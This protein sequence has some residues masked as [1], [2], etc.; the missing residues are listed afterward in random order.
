MA[1]SRAARGPRDPRTQHQRLSLRAAISIL[2]Q[3]RKVGIRGLQVARLN[4]VQRGHQ[5]FGISLQRAFATVTEEKYGG[6]HQQREHDGAH[7]V[8]PVFLPDAEILIGAYRV[9][10]LAQQGVVLCRSCLGL[11]VCC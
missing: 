5:N 1:R 4:L 8:E 2:G 6:K 7:D 10:D 3:R 11:A 9:V